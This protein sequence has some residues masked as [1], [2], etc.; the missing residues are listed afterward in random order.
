MHRESGGDEQHDDAEKVADVVEASRLR[1][2]RS[3]SVLH[4]DDGHA[5]PG[6]FQL[7]GY[8]ASCTAAEPAQAQTACAPKGEPADQATER[9]HGT[10]GEH[11]LQPLPPAQLCGKVHAHP[12][13]RMLSRPSMTVRSM[14]VGSVGKTVAAAVGTLLGWMMASCTWRVATS[15]KMRK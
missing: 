12:G 11:Q 9:N 3:I 10:R 14:L 7:L 8:H 13:K 4:V 6:P 2:T 5:P 15:N 1:W